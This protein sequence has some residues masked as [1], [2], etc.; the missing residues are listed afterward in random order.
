MPNLR[1]D[2]LPPIGHITPVYPIYKK[3]LKNTEKIEK[4]SSKNP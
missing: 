3:L 4:K 2:H 1:D